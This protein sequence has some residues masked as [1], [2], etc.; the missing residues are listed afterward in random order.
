MP[1]LLSLRYA[2]PFFFALSLSLASY[3]DDACA[4]VGRWVTPGNEGAASLEIP[5]LMTRLAQRRVV[6]LG[7]LHDSFEHHRWQLQTLAALYAKQP[8]M[9]LGFEM[10]PRRVQD[11]LDRWVEGSLS[12]AEFLKQ[13]EWHKVWNYDP[14]L[15]MPLFHFARMNRIPMLALNVDR[16]LTT[17]V[18]EHGWDAMPENER[19]GVSKPAPAQPAYLEELLGIYQTHGRSDAKHGDTPKNAKPVALDD[20][21]FLRFVQGQ[22]VWDRAMA[23]TIARAVKKSSDALVVGILGAGHVMHR[24]GVPYQLEDL[25]VADSTV[26]LAWD[27]ERDCKDLKPGIAEAVFGIA[28]PAEAAQA[29]KPR[30]GVILDGAEGKVRIAKVMEDGVGDAAGI[31]ANDVIIE[32]AGVKIKEAGEVSTLVQRQAPGTWLPITLSREGHEF[33]IVAKFPASP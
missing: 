28:A 13:S 4:P 31:I 23:E 22:Q 30:L 3:G 7:E 15:Y 32:M 24:Y 17:K 18:R 12:E 21:D 6:L 19:Q 11:V 20:P 9:V 1:S 25:G 8:D 14:S 2:L 33:D 16:G 5:D 29:G 10:F 26:L 27:Q